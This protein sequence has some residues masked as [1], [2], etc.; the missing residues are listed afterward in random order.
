MKHCL[1]ASSAFWTYFLTAAQHEEEVRGLTC[2]AVVTMWLVCYGETKVFMQQ[3]D[4][5]ENTSHILLVVHAIS[6]TVIVG[7]Q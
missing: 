6:Y 7:D 1:S 5:K 4:E 3:T 2:T